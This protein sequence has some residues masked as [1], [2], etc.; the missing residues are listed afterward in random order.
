MRIRDAKWSRRW[1]NAL[2]T[3]FWWCTLYNTLNHLCPQIMQRLQ[4]KVM[5]YSYTFLAWLL[6]R[7]CTLF[8]FRYF[9]FIN[10]SWTSRVLLLWIWIV[11]I[12]RDVIL[13]QLIHALFS[14]VIM[15]NDEKLHTIQLVESLYYRKCI[16]SSLY[17]QLIMIMLMTSRPPYGT[18]IIARYW[19]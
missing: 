2:L 19:F 1:P 7:T 9:I 17:E 10:L 4:L 6:N 13:I 15:L 18:D 16:V 11:Q 14:I 5:N 8:N 12:Y 3:I